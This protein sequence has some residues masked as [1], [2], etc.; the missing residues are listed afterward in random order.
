VILLVAEDEAL[1]ALVLEL[2]L[3]GAGHQVLGPAATP[4]EALA[5]AEGTRPELAL[6][7][8]RLEDGGDGIALART[9]RDR[10]GVPSLFVSGQVPDALAA[11]DAA[12]GLVRKPYA[13]EDVARAV[14]VVAE[15][16]RGR[17]PARLP[18]GLE[19]FGGTEP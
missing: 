2:E 17:R 8:I 12:L 16:L 4:E 18:P 11:K 1:I 9:L 5:L 14:E 13:P 7:D 19:L 15:L 6:I 3:R 10:H